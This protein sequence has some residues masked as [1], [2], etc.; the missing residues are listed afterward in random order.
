MSTENRIAAPDGGFYVVT[1][2]GHL[3]SVKTMK[4]GQR[5]ATDDDLVKAAA[6]EA[7]RAKS[8]SAARVGGPLKEV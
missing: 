4:D 5:L 6:I 2:V 1:A 7:K 8:E 3:V